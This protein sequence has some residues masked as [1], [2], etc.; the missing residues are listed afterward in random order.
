MTAALAMPCRMSAYDDREDRFLAESDAADS[1][2]GLEQN[3]ISAVSDA[4]NRSTLKPIRIMLV[5]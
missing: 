4:D 3:P 1:A 5:S 2:S